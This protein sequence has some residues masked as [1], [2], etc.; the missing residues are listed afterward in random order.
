MAKTK[1]NYQSDS[2]AYSTSPQVRPDKDGF[3]ATGSIQSWRGSVQD[4]QRVVSLAT[5]ALARDH[6]APTTRLIATDW[7]G[8]SQ[9][10]AQ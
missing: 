7:A 3:S 9:N 10:T 4:I 6:L 5:D 1:P 8:V 2:G